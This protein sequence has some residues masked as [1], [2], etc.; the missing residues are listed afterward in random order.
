MINILAI[1][2][3]V[4]DTIRTICAF[5]CKLI[6]PLISLMYE[7]FINLSSDKILTS[8]DIKPIYER[9]TM[10][11]AIIMVFYVTFEFVKYVIQPDTMTDKEKG[12]TSVIKK[13]ILIVV[14]IALVPSA[15]DYAY[16]FQKRIFDA[17]VFSKVILGKENTNASSVGKSF[18]TN[19]FSIFYGI[20]ETSP[21]YNEESKN[22]NCDGLNCRLLVRFNL[23]MLNTNGKL[24]FLTEGLNARG[25]LKPNETEGF[26]KK[27]N[28][29]LINFNG[30]FA[31]IAGIFILYM[32][33]MYCVDVGIRIAQLTFLQIIAPIPIIGYLSPKKDGIFQKWV[34]QCITTYLDIFIRVGIIYFVML[35]CQ[36]FTNAY[37]NAYQNG[38]LANISA[39]G[40]I[41]LV[42]GL[43]LFAKKAPKMLEELFPKMGA[44][45]GNFGLKVQDRVAPMAARTIGAGLGITKGVSN[46]IRK[47]RAAA[48]RNKANGTDNSREGR[49]KNK[50]LQ[51][52]VAAERRK[53]VALKSQEKDLRKKETAEKEMIS[54]R[55][56]K[57]QR[58]NAKK[59]L[60]EAKKTGDINKIQIANKK[61]QIADKDFKQQIRIAKEANEQYNKTSMHQSAIVQNKAQIAD[62][63]ERYRIAKGEYEKIKNDP[64]STE[65]QR[66]Y[67]KAN[68]E[69]IQKNSTIGMQEKLGNSS[70][71]L[72]MATTEVNSAKERL[73]VAQSSGNE[74]EIKAAE[75]NLVQKQENLN[76]EKQ[77]NLTT[78]EDNKKMIKKQIVNDQSDAKVSYKDENGLDQ[79][80]S[81]KDTEQLRK[82]LGESRDNEIIAT[83]E[84][85]KPLT[86]ATLT[87]LARGVQTGIMQ[88]WKSQKIEDISKNLKSADKEL[89]S[90]QQELNKYYDSG[91]EGGFKGYVNRTLQSW[92]KQHG[93]DTDYDRAILEAKAHETEIKNKEAAASTAD[94][95]YKSVT[96]TKDTIKGSLNK[97]DTKVKRETPE[98]VAVQN[99]INDNIKAGVFDIND[100][101]IPNDGETSV[102]N[103]IGRIRQQRKNLQTR[104]EE[105]QKQYV[106]REK[107]LASLVDIRNKE[108][109]PARKTEITEE[110][111]R[112]EE[113]RKEA[114]KASEKARIAEQ[115][116]ALSEKQ[117][118]TYQFNLL[119]KNK[120]KEINDTEVKDIDFDAKM[121]FNKVFNATI[122]A[123]Q[124]PE[125]VSKMGIIYKNDPEKYRIFLT[126]KYP[127]Y[128]TLKEI[129]EKL[130]ELSGEFSGEAGQLKERQRAQES[131]IATQSMK[132]ASDYKANPNSDK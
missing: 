74:D 128:A 51:D 10:I 72:K 24:S 83:N 3:I 95:Y 54:L 27:V 111:A 108:T 41:F 66:A 12:A 43:M 7:L 62:N 89:I 29:Y 103:T 20:D 48:I 88:G 102:K 25:N 86:T 123:T 105:K 114:E 80:L 19:V 106:E 78:M 104:A 84:M 31:V 107:D 9:I 8:S 70:E 59:E 32:L 40:Y 81:I 38:R 64:N 77:K 68:F 119:L 60:D 1:E 92:E 21:L 94:A 90:R 57:T 61:F 63:N 13:L 50:K 16:E 65:E 110:I 113:L 26:N 56:K 131:S 98:L 82:M 28:V 39:I 14:L 44:A 22:P 97:T 36:V 58:D 115:V 79:D 11:L 85:H 52:R 112:I 37:Q 132:A 127:D 55:T 17:Q 117:L 118:T 46:A 96:G 93:W 129:S 45:S 91:G 100:I 101:Q 15:F 76:K 109:D 121:A 35:L 53:Q 33:I 69:R 71:N 124:N 73:K 99:L 23:E 5:L 6:Y 18:A 130:E 47:T 2:G 122:T 116:E 34:K 120:N 42:M 87:G 126:G 4:E 49:M 67:A 30:L 125:L 75:M